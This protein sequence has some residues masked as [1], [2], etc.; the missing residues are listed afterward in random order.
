MIIAYYYD[1]GKHDLLRY[2]HK[3]NEI[4]HTVKRELTKKEILKHL[5]DS[6]SK[7]Y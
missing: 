7:L 2:L 3:V 4:L 5:D 6:S 1:S